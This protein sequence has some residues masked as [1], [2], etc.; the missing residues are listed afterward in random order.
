MSVILGFLLFLSLSLNFYFL[1]EV[2]KWKRNYLHSKVAQEN[3]LI[4]HQE[5]RAKRNAM[6]DVPIIQKRGMK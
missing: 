4:I 2:K 5:L 1:L 3:K 6:K